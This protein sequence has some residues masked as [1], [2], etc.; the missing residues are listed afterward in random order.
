MKG[1]TVRGYR[2]KS[3]AELLK[4]IDG[5]TSLSQLFA[6]IQL[7]G[8]VIQMHSQSGASNLT[9]KT[10]GPG[11][12]ISKKDTPFERLKAEVRKAVAEGK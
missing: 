4:A 12:I 3:K 1:A 6:L 7:E 11:E 9:P 5:C 8:I 2:K 10:L